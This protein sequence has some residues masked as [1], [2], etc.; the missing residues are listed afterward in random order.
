MVRP[1]DPA[2]AE[3]VSR[4]IAVTMR[5]SNS[6][7]YS[8]K[9]LEPLIAYFSPAKVRQLGVERLC[10]IAVDGDMVVGTAALD[11]DRLATFFVLPEYQ[12][13]GIGTRLLTQLEDAAASAGLR[14]LLVDASVTGAAFYE[15]RGYRRTGAIK[16]GT[17]GTQI[18]LVKEI[19][20]AGG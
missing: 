14:V 6:Q 1:F 7:H 15:C 9:Q 8:A 20:P 5:E 18:E 11:G 13:R 3:Q 10:L 2:D 4:V 19:R 16:D 12:A 17:G